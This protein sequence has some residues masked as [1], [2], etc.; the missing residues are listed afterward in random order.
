MVSSVVWPCK[1]GMTRRPSSDLK[2]RIA[3]IVHRA[4]IE[5]DEEGTEAAAGTAPRMELTSHLEPVAPEP[6]RVDRPFLFYFVGDATGA[7]LFQGMISD[8]RSVLSG[9]VDTAGKPG[10]LDELLAVAW[11]RA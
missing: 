7:I 1:A 4:V 2:L 9:A 6:F 5:V 3:I 11:Y 10:D 8:P